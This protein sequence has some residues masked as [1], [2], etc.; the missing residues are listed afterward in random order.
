M[1]KLTPA[2]YEEA[3]QLFRLGE[4][5]VEQIAVKFGVHKKT[6]QRRFDKDKVEVDAKAVADDARRQI[7]EQKKRAATG[8]LKDQALI[9]ETKDTHYKVAR[10]LTA[11]LMTKIKTQFDKKERLGIIHDDVK[12][13]KLALEANELARKS[14]Y[15]ILNI[16]GESDNAQDYTE[17]PILE[18][19][20]EEARSLAMQRNDGL[21]F[22]ETEPE[23]SEMGDVTSDA[24]GDSG[25]E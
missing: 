24:D 1:R 10:S 12:V 11:V 17:L 14:R 16:D 4:M 20:D 7:E 6:I 18:V 21:D 8:Q 19:T 3:K 22:A 23:L 13:L 25:P 9:K 15:A 5:S 2:Q